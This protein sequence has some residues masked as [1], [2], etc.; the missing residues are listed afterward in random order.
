MV[1][2]SHAEIEVDVRVHPQQEVLEDH[3]PPPR[4]G[5]EGQP[6]RAVDCTAVRPPFEV[7]EVAAGE[8]DDEVLHP[9]GVLER[10]R[11][12]AFGDGAGDRHVHR[13][14]VADAIAVPRAPADDLLEGVDR[15][16]EAGAHEGER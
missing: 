16:V 11:S 12:C 5:L 7:A 9:L 8:G 10:A 2:C 3:R 15:R 4:S 6:P 13:R 14:E 1:G